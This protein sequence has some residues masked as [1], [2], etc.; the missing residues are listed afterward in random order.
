MSILTKYHIGF[1]ISHNC[2]NFININASFF[3][4]AKNCVSS[5]IYS[6]FK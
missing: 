3:Q 6:A 5:I 4:N 2:Y 1:I